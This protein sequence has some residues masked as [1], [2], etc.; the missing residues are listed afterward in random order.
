MKCLV[1]VVALA[2]AGLASCSRSIDAVVPLD[3]TAAASGDPGCAPTM[4]PTA[5][6][7]ANSDPWLVAH[8]D[9]ITQMAPRVM[10]LDFDNG[11]TPDQVMATAQHQACRH[12][13]GLSLSRLRGQHRASLF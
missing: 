10:V 13:G 8:H 6:H 9:V 1:A 2:A 5:E 12:R 3:C 7:G 11:A 4:W